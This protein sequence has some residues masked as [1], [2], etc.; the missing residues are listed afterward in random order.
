[1]TGSSFLCLIAVGF[2]SFISCTPA[3]KYLRNCFSRLALVMKEF[4][5]SE[6]NHAKADLERDSG[7]NR[8]LRASTA[9]A[10]THWIRN[11]LMCFTVVMVKQ[12]DH[13]PQ[14][15]AYDT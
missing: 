15:K 10:S 2:V 4:G 5:G 8:I 12:S 1:M 7:N 14:D 3:K 6:V 9:E 11:W 13:K